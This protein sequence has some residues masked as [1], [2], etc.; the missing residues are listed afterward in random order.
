VSTDA[1]RDFGTPTAMGRGRIGGVTLA[2]LSKA[3]RGDCAQDGEHA[4]A[5]WAVRRA[6]HRSRFLVLHRYG[7]RRLAHYESGAAIHVLSGPDLM[8]RVMTQFH[9]VLRAGDAFLNNSP[10]HGCSHAADTRCSCP[11]S[12]TP[13][14]IGLR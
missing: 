11:S 3:P 1:H 7:E 6:Q 12:T 8:A 9:P 10:Y 2:I 4:A 13:E 5:H 14:Y